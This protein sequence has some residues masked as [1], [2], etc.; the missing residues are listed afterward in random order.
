MIFDENSSSEGQIARHIWTALYDLGLT[1]PKVGSGP[2]KKIPG[3][4]IP[5][6][7]SCH[8]LC[9]RRSISDDVEKA[10]RKIAIPQCKRIRNYVNPDS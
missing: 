9:L 10:N 3:A 4:F 1:W 2:A 6:G 8:G 5:D 7:P